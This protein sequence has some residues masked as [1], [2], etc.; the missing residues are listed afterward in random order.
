MRRPRWDCFHAERLRKESRT[1]QG[2]CWSGLPIGT[3]LTLHASFAGVLGTSIRVVSGRR[4]ASPIHLSTATTS[5]GFVVS[6][7]FLNFFS[8]SRRVAPD[9]H[10]F[11]RE[12]R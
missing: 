10:F 5:S 9:E 7:K 4:V 11:G 2:M 12:A 3:L 6:V 8:L 1:W